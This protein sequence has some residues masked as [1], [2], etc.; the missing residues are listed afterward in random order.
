MVIQEQVPLAPFTTFQIG[1]AAHQLVT[2]Q[3]TKE[4]LA[5]YRYAQD[6]HIPWH[7]LAGGSNVIFPDEGMQGLIIRLAGGESRINEQRISAEAG[8]PL[9]QIIQ[10]AIKQGLVGLEALSGIPGTIGG[11]VVGNAGAYGHSIAEVIEMVQVFDGKTTQ[12]FSREQCRFTYRH[13]IFK[14][15]PLIVLGATL[16][17]HPGN[18]DTLAAQSVEIIKKREAKYPPGVKTAGSFFKNLL[19]S[20]L[21]ETQ[22]EKIDRSKIIEGKIPTGYLLDTVGARGMR[23]GDIQVSDAHGNLLVNTGAGTAKDVKELAR[24]LKEKVKAHFDILLEEEV[25]YM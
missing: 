1:G 6:A 9:M 15:K 24:Q 17:L 4:L 8:V 7:M 18:R 23:V 10:I 25:R 13:S 19:A 2:V 3:S 16:R 12:E 21:S 22:M 14:E 5:A 11:A 20:S